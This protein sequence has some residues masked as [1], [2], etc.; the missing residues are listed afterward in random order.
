MALDYSFEIHSND[1]HAL[2]EIIEHATSSSPSGSGN[3]F[4]FDAVGISCSLT[5][6]SPLGDELSQEYFEF[7]TEMVI[8][9]R[10]EK[11]EKRDEGMAK[12]L[13]ICDILLRE[14]TVDFVF[15]S[16]DVVLL[17]RRNSVIHAD[18]SDPY[19][20]RWWKSILD[21]TITVFERISKI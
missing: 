3:S 1:V 19:W 12:L 11:F 17:F 18:I 15:L 6:Q 20:I 21:S 9:C 10:V 7:A 16:E 14:T 8:R 2:L 13:T 5:E 4:I